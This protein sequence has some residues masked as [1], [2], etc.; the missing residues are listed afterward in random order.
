MPTCPSCRHVFRTLPGEEQ[1]HECPRCGYEPGEE[2]ASTTAT[3][4]YCEAPIP[5]LTLAF[6]DRRGDEPQYIC[7]A[8]LEAKPWLELEEKANEEQE[9]TG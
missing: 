7:L 6:V 8:C 2:E 3:C 1:D 4:Q 9:A 5:D